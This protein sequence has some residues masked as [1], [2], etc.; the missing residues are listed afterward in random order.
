MHFRKFFV[1]LLLLTTAF[2][3][4][5]DQV[6][7][8]MD[9]RMV[10]VTV[11]GPALTSYYTLRTTTGDT[12]RTGQENIGGMAGIYPILDDSYQSIL[13]GRT[14]NFIFR[15][16][17]NDSLVVNESYGISADECHIAYASGNLNV[18]L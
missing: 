10:T 3:C 11:T 1:L 5:E 17:I 6:A 14:E 12:I 18:T 9:F 4:K 13:E 2:A 7:C 16:F 15:G 8:T